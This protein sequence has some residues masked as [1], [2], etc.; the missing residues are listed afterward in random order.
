M[1]CLICE[2]SL[3]VFPCNYPKEKIDSIIFNRLKKI[4]YD[5]R[6]LDNYVAAYNSL[7]V[8]CPC[9]ECLVKSMCLKLCPDYKERVACYNQLNVTDV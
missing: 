6:D 4:P 5:E 1:P 7:T 2:D 3:S 9:K 8:F